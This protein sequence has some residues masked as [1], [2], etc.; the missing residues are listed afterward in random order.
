MPTLNEVALKIFDRLFY[1][2]DIYQLLITSFLLSL[3]DCYSPYVFIKTINIYILRMKFFFLI[4]GK[5]FFN[6]H[7]VMKIDKNNVKP[8][9]IFEK[10]FYFSPDFIHLFLYEY[11]YKI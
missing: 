11:Y 7:E 8:Y 4:L 10:Y 1:Y 2:Y 5:I 6:S 3:P 9:S